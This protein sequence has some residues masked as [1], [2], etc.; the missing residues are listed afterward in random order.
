MSAYTKTWGLAVEL[1]SNPDGLNR[2]GNLAF[3]RS[4]AES[5]RDK[6]NQWHPSNPVV[7]INLKSEG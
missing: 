5:Y 3:T 1:K 6:W 2:I 4:D 7:V